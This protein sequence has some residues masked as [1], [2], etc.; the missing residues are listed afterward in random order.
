MTTQNLIQ[1]WEKEFIEAG[2]DLEHD[3]WARWQKYLH[4]LCY[5]HK[6]LSYNSSK[7]DYEDIETGGLVI[8]KSR[9]EH[10]ERQINTSY[11]DLSEKEK[12]YDR[13]EVRKYLP[14]IEKLV[15]SAKREVIGE[16][17]NIVETQR[18]HGDN[19]RN[20]EYV[21]ACEDIQQG[22]SSLKDKSDTTS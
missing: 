11:S 13:I 19:S 21:N 1:D 8:P 22:I 10:W 14:L 4:S 2:A 5:P 20:W 9:V 3:R 12:E 7:R 17:E 15:A 6:L 18:I 16:V